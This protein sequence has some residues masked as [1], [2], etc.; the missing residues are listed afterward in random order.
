MRP[1]E[2]LIEEL[3]VHLAAE[4]GLSYN[5]LALTQRSLAKFI[6][7]KNQTNPDAG[8]ARTTTDEIRSFLKSE[9]SRGLSVSSVKILVA[10]LKLW[11]GF[12]KRNKKIRSD[13]TELMHFPKVGIHLPTFLNER[14]TEQLFS[15]VDFTKRPAPGRNRFLPLRDRAILELL[16]ASGVRNSE[17]CT[18]QLQNL[19]LARRTLRVI[20][21]GSK[22]RMVVFGRPAAAAVQAYLEHERAQR[23]K[24]ATHATSRDRESIFVS[25]N[26]QQITYQRCW[27]L[28]QE[29][30]AL[31]GLEKPIY[32]HLLRHTF[33]THLLAHGAD[34]RVIQELLGHADILTT[35]IYCHV[36]FPHIVSVYRACHP[37]AIAPLFE[38]VP[39]CRSFDEAR[40]SWLKNKCPRLV[41]QRNSVLL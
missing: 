19:D 30:R 14:E 32:P 7:W 15:V 3:L 13:P 34:L 22:E 31:C 8:V 24:R 38:I 9:Q 21:K 26:G 4:R 28:L 2:E 25:W 33:A 20:G 17:L 11:F 5:Y 10:A 1:P 36:A 39:S 16:Y 41:A 40:A 12:L 35:S 29:T 27:Q 6:A 37:R 18:A 23:V